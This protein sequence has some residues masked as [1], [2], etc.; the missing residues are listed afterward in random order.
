M[1][2]QEARGIKFVGIPQVL[3]LDKLPHRPTLEQSDWAAD[4]PA[5]KLKGDSAP[6]IEL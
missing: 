1:H 4:S 6:N 3:N 5:G 2:G